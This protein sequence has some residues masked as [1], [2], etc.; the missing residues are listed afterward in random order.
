[1]PLLCTVVQGKNSWSSQWWFLRHF[2]SAVRQKLNSRHFTNK[3]YQWKHP[4]IISNYYLLLCCSVVNQKEVWVL[5]YKLFCK[6]CTAKSFDFLI[7][8]ILNSF[9]SSNILH[10]S[11]FRS[12]NG[13]LT[14]LI[15]CKLDD[16]PW[17]L[18][19]KANFVFLI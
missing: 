3:C 12:S 8:F 6:S 11:I 1:M 5:D 14:F 16:A 10:T 13:S 7:I 15:S 19:C 17:K 18:L 9:R 4:D 2:Y